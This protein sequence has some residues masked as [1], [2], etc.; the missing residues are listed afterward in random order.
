M[1]AS[2]GIVGLNLF[3]VLKSST[4]RDFMG[5]ASKHAE[6]LFVL[7]VPPT[8]IDLSTEQGPRIISVEA[9][10]VRN[11]RTMVCGIYRRAHGLGTTVPILRWSAGEQ[12]CD[13][14]LKT[15]HL[16]ETHN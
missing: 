2:T 13:P 1:Y 4:D 15:S 16:R 11:C 3:T 8:R 9:I 14:S 12:A 6:I 7:C 5:A 10:I